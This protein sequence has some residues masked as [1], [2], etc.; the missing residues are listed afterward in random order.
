MNLSCRVACHRSR[1]PHPLQVRRQDDFVCLFVCLFVV[2]RVY[3]HATGQNP[4]QRHAFRLCDY[5]KKYG[6][7]DAVDRNMAARSM[8]D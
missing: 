6:A 4:S 3:K 7:R 2:L 1:P 5:V 8:L